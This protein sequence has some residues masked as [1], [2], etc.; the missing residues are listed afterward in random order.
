M[1]K[2]KSSI[3]FLCLITIICSFRVAP[4][5]P[6]FPEMVKGKV[7]I[8]NDIPLESIKITSSKSKNET[9]SNAKGEFTIEVTRKDKLRFTAEGFISQRVNIKDP[10]KVLNIE[11]ELLS[12]DFSDEDEMVND[13]FRYIPKDHRSTAMERLKER[14]ANEFA[15]YTSVWDI[16]RNRI[17]GVVVQN[18]NAYFRE[19]L[20]GSISTESNPAVIV[21]NGTR[22]SSDT[23]TNLDP[24]NVKE[25]TLLKGSA[26]TVYGGSGGAGVIVITTK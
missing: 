19:G 2:I 12:D 10:T 22:T 4:F 24:R 8:W 20:S 13:G 23:V 15:S 5:L 25:I 26:A 6:I 21:L 18:N 1:R 11:M 7:T 16:I 9:A 14:R 17:A 3:V